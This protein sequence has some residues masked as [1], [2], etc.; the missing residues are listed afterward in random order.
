M[1]TEVVKI[2]IELQLEKIGQNQAELNKFV[3]N[4]QT[5]LVSLQKTTQETGSFFTGLGGKLTKA[6]VQRIIQF[7]IATAFAGFGALN[8]GIALLGTLKNALAAP[9]DA[10]IENEKAVKGLGFALDETGRFSKG[11]TDRLAD[12]AEELEKTSRF[13]Q[14]AIIANEEYFASFTKLSEEGIKVATQVSVD[15]AAKLGIG[16][17][18]ATRKV[19]D[20]LAGGTV[21]LKGTVIQL[22]KA[23][24]SADQ[25]TKS[26]QILNSFVGGAAKADISTFGGAVFQTSVAIGDFIKTIGLAIIN[27]PAIKATIL[28]AIDALNL[29]TKTIKDNSGL[30]RAAFDIMVAGI[31]LLTVRLAGLTFATLISSC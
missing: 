24:D 31:A 29:A 5:Q 21:V 10:A 30:I 27:I 12:Y 16:L 18:A 8:Q 20:S 25:A 9:I 14:E 17:D 23:A 4:I 6:F 13:S 1:A 22:G 2:P 26:L 19:A 28:L 7:A 11:A 15:L 3:S